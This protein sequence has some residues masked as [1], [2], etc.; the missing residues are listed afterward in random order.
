MSTIAIPVF[1]EGVSFPK[2][3]PG[4]VPRAWLE[5]ADDADGHEFKLAVPIEFA[6]AIAPLVQVEDGEEC[7]G[8]ITIAFGEP[9]GDAPPIPEPTEHVA[10]RVSAKGLL[11]LK[12]DSLLR[13]RGFWPNGW[14]RP[15]GDRVDLVAGSGG[16]LCFEFTPAEGPSTIDMSYDALDAKTRRRR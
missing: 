9:E 6:R 5:L 4:G 8:E 7:V 16:K 14:E 10:G 3:K 13:S 12:A 15:N 1:I 2:K 11:A